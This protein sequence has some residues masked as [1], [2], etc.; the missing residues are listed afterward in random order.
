MHSGGKTDMATFRVSE[1]NTN[2]LL[3]RM[4]ATFD[5][6]GAGYAAVLPLVAKAEAGRGSDVASP[7]IGITD[8]VTIISS[9]DV[10]MPAFWHAT[11]CT[12]PLSPMA[13][14]SADMDGV[15][16]LTLDSAPPRFTDHPRSFDDL[17]YVP[18]M[19]SKYKEPPMPARDGSIVEIDQTA[20]NVARLHSYY[21]ELQTYHQQPIGPEYADGYVTRRINAHMS[22]EH[23][24]VAALMYLLCKWRDAL[25][26][27]TMNMDWNGT[28]H[29]WNINYHGGVDEALVWFAKHMLE[30]AQIAM[31]EVR[32]VCRCN[33]LST[34][35][36]TLF[37]SNLEHRQQIVD[38]LVHVF[39]NKTAGHMY[40]TTQYAATTAD[41][42]GTQRHPPENLFTD[43]ALFIHKERRI[44]PVNTPT[45]VSFVRG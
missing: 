31:G 28:F 16:T 37:E 7:G 3:P 44:I 12:G 19:L 38:G 45:G 18:V 42:L 10:S 17:G 5:S 13:D 35:V 26:M 24:C 41:E 20:L 34:F 23:D 30:D 39:H 14:D 11:L 8:D 32:R 43:K 1:Q 9:T 2:H 4:T 40:G 36:R 22:C 33:T 27:S 25:D 6:K 15:T 29:Q 21:T